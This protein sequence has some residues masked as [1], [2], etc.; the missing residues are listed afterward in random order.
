MCANLLD[1]LGRYTVF[2]RDPNGS[3]GGGGVCA[4]TKNVRSAEVS[5]IDIYA[6]LENISI[7]THLGSFN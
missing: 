3:G 5:V 2:Q 1:H 6:D 4:L 7:L